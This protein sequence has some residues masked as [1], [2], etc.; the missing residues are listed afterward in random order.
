MSVN[1]KVQAYNDLHVSLQRNPLDKQI[2]LNYGTILCQMDSIEQGIGI[3]KQLIREDKNDFIACQNI[4]YFSM[5]K[6]KYDTALVYFNRALSINPKLGLTYNNR[7]FL[8][9][10]M[11]N[12]REALK[13]INTSLKLDKTNAFAYKNRALISIAE[14]RMEDAC[15]DLIKARSLGYAEKYGNEVNQLIQQNCKGR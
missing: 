14:G 10:K 13:D 5:N 9:Y 11:G 7:G 6:E 15:A 2:R 3:F 4:G 8:E 1:N 12:N